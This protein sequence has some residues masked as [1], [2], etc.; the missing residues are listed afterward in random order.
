MRKTPDGGIAISGHGTS[1]PGAPPEGYQIEVDEK[2]GMY[3]ATPLPPGPLL[4]GEPLIPGG[5]VEHEE[6]GTSTEGESRGIGAEGEPHSLWDTLSPASAYAAWTNPGN[7]WG[8]VAIVGIDPVNI[9]VCALQSEL[10]W[11]VDWVGNIGTNW[12]FD[13]L[14]AVHPTS[15]GTNWWLDWYANG[16]TW[17]EQFNYFDGPEPCHGAQAQFY[18]VDF[19]PGLPARSYSN[20]TT[21]KFETKIC[22]RRDGAKDWWWWWRAGPYNQLLSARVYY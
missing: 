5:T 18:N 2:R 20:R 12:Y 7:W 15:A 8:R 11:W 9:R 3:K 1:K 13:H 14:E 10:S 21:L 22:G 17:W 6:G 4:P 16:G 19:P